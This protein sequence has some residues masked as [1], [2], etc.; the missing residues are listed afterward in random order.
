MIARSETGQLNEIIIEAAASMEN[1]VMMAE[2]NARNGESLAKLIAEQGVELRQFNDDI[3]DAFGE[4]AE[5]VFE[6]VQ[7]H[8]D[9]T[10]RIHESFVNARAQVGGWTKIADQSYVAQRNRYL[11]L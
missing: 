1:D 8:D 2:F 11:G 3:Y 6:E 9:L 7:E 10:K 4:A 5:E